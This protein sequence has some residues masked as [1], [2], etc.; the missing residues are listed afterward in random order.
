MN[1][2]ISKYE[3]YPQPSPNGL[4]VGFSISLDNGK[5][6][7]IDTIVSMDLSEQEAIEAAWN[8]LKSSIDSR[9]EELSKPEQ[10]AVLQSSAL[11]KAFIPSVSED[12][13]GQLIA[14]VVEEII[15]EPVI[16]ETPVTEVQEELAPVVEEVILEPVVEETPVEEVQEELAPEE[17]LVEPAVEE[18]V[19]LEVTNYEDMTVVELKAL[20]SERGL[21]GYSSMTKS[22]LVDLHEDY[23]LSN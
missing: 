3:L 6:F 21:S 16:E 8:S 7:Y 15:S 2:K 13:H 9:I 1:V 11:G 10:T 20:A 12:S 4:A 18:E 23:D 22:E 19:E 17:T 5:S 14:P